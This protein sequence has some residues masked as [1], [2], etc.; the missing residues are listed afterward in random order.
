MFQQ[1][2]NASCVMEERGSGGTGPGGDH[3]QPNPAAAVLLGRPKLAR[4]HTAHALSLH[5]VLSMGLEM[6]SHAHDCWP[7]VFR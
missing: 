4:L 3:H 7:H 5:L 1:L 6:G 2:A